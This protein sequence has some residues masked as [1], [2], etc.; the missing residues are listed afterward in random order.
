MS[1]EPIF[2]VIRAITA[3][4]GGSMHVRYASGDHL[5]AE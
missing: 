5:S 1:S 4:I 3:D 2:T